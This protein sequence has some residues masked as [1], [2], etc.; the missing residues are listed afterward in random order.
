MWIHH[1][2][3]GMQ[4]HQREKSST[5]AV[6]VLRVL[7]VK[8]PPAEDDPG[9]FGW[10]DIQELART[11]RFSGQAED[12]VCVFQRALQLLNL[13]GNR[14]GLGIYEQRC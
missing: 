2:L 1:H 11:T 5:Y 13:V 4:V 14:G 10:P 9:L 3:D 8:V 6:Q 7:T 12:A